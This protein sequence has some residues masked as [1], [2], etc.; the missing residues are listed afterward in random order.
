MAIDDR[1]TRQIAES[2]SKLKQLDF[3]LAVEREVNRRLRALRPSGSVQRP[4]KDSSELR[5]LAMH[6]MN[7]VSGSIADHTVR[8]LQEK[9]K[10]M[11]GRDIA[12]ELGN[13]GVTT[14]AKGGLLPM[15]LSAIRRRSDVFKRVRRGTYTL[16]ER[17]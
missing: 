12:R 16:E 9:G 8:L 3:A 7:L 1:L 14:T 5:G 13:R 17:G 6:S 10:P 2:D 15:V 11:R 4:S